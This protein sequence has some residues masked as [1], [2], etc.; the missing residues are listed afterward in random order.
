MWTIESR[1]QNIYFCSD[2]KSPSLST[3]LQLLLHLL[4]PLLPLVVV[5]LV[6]PGLLQVA[7]LVHKG[8]GQD[9]G[10]RVGVL[11]GLSLAIQAQGRH[12]LNEHRFN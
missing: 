6:P 3:S 5:D 9:L 8:P 4:E 12:G 2:Q 7:L 10:P 11:Q 1:D